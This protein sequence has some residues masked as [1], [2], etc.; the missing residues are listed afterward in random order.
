MAVVP[1]DERAGAA[2]GRAIAS[3]AACT[4]ALAGQLIEALVSSGR[5]SRAVVMGERDS[6]AFGSRPER[7]RVVAD[8]VVQVDESRVTTKASPTSISG[9]LVKPVGAGALP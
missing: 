2:R 5:A 7:Q 3:G 6:S 4:S 1:P 9:A 8:V